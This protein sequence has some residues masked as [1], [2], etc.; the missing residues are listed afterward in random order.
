MGFG[1]CLWWFL[2]GALLGWLLSWLLNRNRWRRDALLA[3]HTTPSPAPAA[4]PVRSTAPDPLPTAVTPSASSFA[5]TSAAAAMAAGITK[6]LK[7]P[8]GYDNFEI[9]EGI[10]PKINGLLHAAGIHSFDRLAGTEVAALSKILDAAG[11]NFRL[12]NPETWARQA[13]LCARGEWEA[14][15]RLQ[16]EL[17]AGVT[18]KSDASDNA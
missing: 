9:I 15:K 11:P 2:F 10:G 16:D 4:A 7:T 5:A 17:V 14:L 8:E 3:A 6:K 13:A 12:A 18:M 1:C